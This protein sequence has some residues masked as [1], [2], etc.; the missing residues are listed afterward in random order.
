MNIHHREEIL[1]RDLVY[2]HLGIKVLPLS[3]NVIENVKV[4]VKEKFYKISSLQES[5]VKRINEFGNYVE[6]M[7]DDFDIVKQPKNTSGRLQS[8]GYPD[9]VID[10]NPPVFLEFKVFKEGTEK[11]NFRSFYITFDKKTTKILKDGS[12]ALLSFEHD[13]SILT[14]NF[15]IKDLYDLRLVTKVEYQSSNDKLYSGIERYK[16]NDL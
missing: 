15:F 4:M 1:F 11:S 14:G 7:L 12:H 2:N 13:G 10:Y 6:T 3:N 16:L 8:V 5:G 9:R